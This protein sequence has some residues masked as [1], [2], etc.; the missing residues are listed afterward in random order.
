MSIFGRKDRLRSLL[1]EDQQRARVVDHEGEALGGIGGIERQIGAARL[2][3]AEKPDHHVERAF[4]AEPDDDIRP[5]AASAQMP[6]ETIGALV[7]L[8][9]G[10][11]R[12]A[13]DDRALPPGCAA[14]ALRTISCRQSREG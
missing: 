14:P 10:K 11:P 6:R 2:Q 3:H 12:L 7:Q 9:I 1:R 5:D 4:D 13:A 8:A